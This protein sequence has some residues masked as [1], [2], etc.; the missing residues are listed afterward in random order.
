MS[1]RTS[2]G[3]GSEGLFLLLAGESKRPFFRI[4]SIDAGRTSMTISKEDRQRDID[5]ALKQ[6]MQIVDAKFFHHVLL[7]PISPKLANI[8]RTTWRDL[9][10]PQYLYVEKADTPIG[11]EAW[12]RLTGRGFKAGLERTGQRTDPITRQNLIE[13]RKA[14]KAHIKEINRQN[15]VPVTLS[16]VA[17]RAHVPLMWAANVIESGLLQDEWPEDKVSVTW[18]SPTEQRKLG[19]I[20]IPIDFGHR[21]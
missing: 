21:K 4:D 7:D 18:W 11:C 1:L 19:M 10:S 16:S 20:R 2:R 9:R 15:E 14:M 6:I 17:Q 8:L 3:S 5:F 12:Y 13:L